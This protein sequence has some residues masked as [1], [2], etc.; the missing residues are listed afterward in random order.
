MA[1]GVQALS[2]L[3]APGF[4]A[5]LEA[6]GKRLAEG[7]AEAA[8]ASGVSV[9]TNRV[10]SMLTSFFTGVA[11]TDYATAKTSDTK[12]YGGFFRAMLDRGVSLAPSQFEAAFISAAHSTED[13]DETVVAA[14]EALAL[15]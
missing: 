4:Y 13:L 15:V 8:T 6:K 1:A 11:V 3:Q 9:H 12:R 10:G 7:L 14:R 5:D 2:L